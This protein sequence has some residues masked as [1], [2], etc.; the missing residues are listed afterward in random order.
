MIA[1][2][3]TADHLGPAFRA[4]LQGAVAWSHDT[5][6]AAPARPHR[7]PVT[8]PPP[9]SRRKRRSRPMTAKAQRRQR[10]KQHNRRV[11]TRTAQPDVDS[12]SPD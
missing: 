1:P 4:G 7:L 5:E 6:A 9:A 12:T 3:E 2:R 8:S 10:M 11:S